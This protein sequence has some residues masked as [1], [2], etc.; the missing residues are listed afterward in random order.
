MINFVDSSN[1]NWFYHE[2][3]FFDPKI[4]NHNKFFNN[5]CNTK[6][7]VKLPIELRKKFE[8]L[9]DSQNFRIVYSQY[10]PDDQSMTYTYVSR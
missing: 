8:I 2:K 1:V 9:I 4:V 10:N 3:T 6:V 7:N 5:S